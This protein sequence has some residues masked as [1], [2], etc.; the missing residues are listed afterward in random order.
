MAFAKEKH[1]L[2][3]KYDFIIQSKNNKIKKIQSSFDSK[4]KTMN[5]QIEH[6]KNDNAIV[7]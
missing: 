5:E 6:L 7:L 2:I 3:L 4:E 1:D